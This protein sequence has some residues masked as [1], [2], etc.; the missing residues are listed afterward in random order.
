MK[1]ENENNFKMKWK[2]WYDSEGGYS[3]RYFIFFI[4]KAEEAYYVNSDIIQK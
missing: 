4:V 1:N 3:M 2:K